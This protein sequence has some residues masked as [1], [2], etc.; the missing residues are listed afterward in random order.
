MTVRGSLLP[1]DLGKTKPSDSPTRMLHDYYIG[2]CQWV[3]T[4]AILGGLNGSDRGL[5]S[6]LLSWLEVVG[7]INWA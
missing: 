2:L 6:R 5:I 7:Y 1:Q 4:E 3:V